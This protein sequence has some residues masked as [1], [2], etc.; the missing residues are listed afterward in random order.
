M[1]ILAIDAST[2]HGAV[3]VCQDQALLSAFASEGK[4]N[5]SE[6]LLPLVQKA[7]KDLGY[8]KGEIDALWGPQLTAAYSAARKDFRK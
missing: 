4:Q 6:T 3:A 2:D 5:H 8:Y 7:L 1:N